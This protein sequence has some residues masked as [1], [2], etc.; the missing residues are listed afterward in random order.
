MPKASVWS[1]WGFS[2]NASPVVRSSVLANEQRGPVPALP[3]ITIVAPCVTSSS[4]P[5]PTASSPEAPSSVPGT[6]RP[7]SAAASAMNA[8]ARASCWITVTPGLVQNCPAP[9]AHDSKSS[10]ATSGSRSSSAP[11]STNTGLTLDISR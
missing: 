11:G 9:I 2:R 6:V 1:A 10:R 5:L 4:M 3:P 7:N 8:S